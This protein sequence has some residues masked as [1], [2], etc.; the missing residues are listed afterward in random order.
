[1]AVPTLLT[2]DERSTHLAPLLAKGWT[3][4][5]GRDAVKKTFLFKDFVH[6]FGFMSH[7]ALVAESK[8]HHP[9]WFNVYNRVEITMSTHD[10]SGLS[11][12]DINLIKVIEEAATAAG[13]NL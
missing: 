1:M 5:E 11:F 12:N 13:A 10:C 7:V 2:A 3:M 6:A 9:E 4:V 8:N